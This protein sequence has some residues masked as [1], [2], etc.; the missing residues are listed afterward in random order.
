MPSTALPE[1]PRSAVFGVPDRDL[2]EEVMA[3]VYATGEETGESLRAQLTDRL[4]SFAIPSRWRIQD[5]PLPTGHSGK[6]DKTAIATEARAALQ[7]EATPS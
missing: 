3:A 4:S 6:I 5:E 1:W 7:A 2:G